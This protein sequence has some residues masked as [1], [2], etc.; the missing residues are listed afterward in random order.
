MKASV[1][2]QVCIG[3]T[4]CTQICPGVFKIDGDKATAY[5]NPVSV[6]K[7]ECARNAAEQCPVQAITLMP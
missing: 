1:D 2:P 5:K 7:N 3:C 4:L 6:D